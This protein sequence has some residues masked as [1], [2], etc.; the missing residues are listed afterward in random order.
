MISG[1]AL[2]L[3]I[4]IKISL[5]HLAGQP[6]SK[7]QSILNVLVHPGIGAILAVIFV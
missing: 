2:I 4:W 6:A 3:I 5:P 7:Q 1:L